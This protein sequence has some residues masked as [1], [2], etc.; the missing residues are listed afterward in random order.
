MAM[1]TMGQGIGGGGVEDVMTTYVP[2]GWYHWMM[3]RG[4]THEN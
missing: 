1:R 4:A 2:V 3:G